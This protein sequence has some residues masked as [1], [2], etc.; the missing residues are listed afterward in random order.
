MGTNGRN[1]VGLKL[2]Q[3]SSDTYVI[4][5]QCLLAEMKTVKIGENMLIIYPETIDPLIYSAQLIDIWQQGDV[6]Y[7]KLY[8]YHKGKGELYSQDLTTEN[9]LFLFASMPFVYKLAE[10]ITDNC[11][12]NNKPVTLNQNKR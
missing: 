1:T 3:L 2:I 8:N 5:H 9:C 7:L 4:Q 6:L 11:K 12:Q 10:V